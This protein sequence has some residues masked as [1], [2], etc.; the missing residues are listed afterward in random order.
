MS[1][2][3]AAAPR[4]R[5]HP[6]EKSGWYCDAC[7]RPLCGQCTAEEVLRFYC[8]HCEGNA[9]QLT[10][11][12]TG[13]PFF[14]MV[15][16]ALV[17][18]VRK[19]L[20]V[21]LGMTV[22][23]AIVTVVE[24]WMKPDVV[25]GAA[26]PGTSGQVASPTGSA[27]VLAPAPAESAA[28]A[29]ADSA[30]ADKKPALTPAEKAAAKKREKAAKDQA[31]KAE[32]GKA[33]RLLCALLRGLLLA[34]AIIIVVG[35]RAYGEMEKGGAWSR[36]YKT[37]LATAVCWVPGVLY[38]FFVQKG[39]PE[40]A[41]TDDW[42]L[43]FYLFLVLLYMP[44]A[45]AVSTSPAPIITPFGLSECMWRVR[46][47]YVFTLVTVVGFAGLA[48]ALQSF[49][50]SERMGLGDIP[51]VASI[52]LQVLL[53]AGALQAGHVVGSLSFVY[54]YEFGW[55]TA[56]DFADP[57]MPTLK[58]TATLKRWAERIADIDK[59]TKDGPTPAAKAREIASCLSA[60]NGAKAVKLYEAQASWDGVTFDPKVILGL[61]TAAVN[62]K[63]PDTAERLL[64]TLTDRNDVTGARALL[65]L[66]KVHETEHKNPMR[67][68][69]IYREV[70]AKFP[71]TDSA[72]FA[73]RRLAT[74]G[75]S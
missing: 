11:P 68:E 29:P 53:V 57:L 58:A 69:S 72:R 67:A 42:L 34:M 41:M 23:L 14:N 55:G 8:V 64:E 10:K 56:D 44:I 21:F 17:E 6:E 75:P 3:V 62:A 30:S 5:T 38:L 65:A 60:G 24:D 39:P 27:E 25:M 70:I 22:F 61:A 20:P 59:S 18:P 26:A 43:W 37:F 36:I 40:A 7:R 4:C 48:V 71:G 45:V 51:L 50:T 54:G 47:R 52:L 31:F 63:K 9:R 12:R 15:L 16:L 32:W 33:I 35:A 19:Q 1:N 74:G 49:L 13:I 73:E 2:A 46:R 28:P 66:A